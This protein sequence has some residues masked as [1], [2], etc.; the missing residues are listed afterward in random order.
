[1]PSSDTLLD[2]FC[3]F[4]AP[5]SNGSAVPTLVKTASTPTTLPDP[6]TGRPIRVATVDGRARAICPSCS[7]SAEGGFLSFVGDLRLVYACPSCEQFVWL[8]G[9]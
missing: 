7:T 1:M 2:P 5:E 8:Q 6:T 9:A 4:F 3:G